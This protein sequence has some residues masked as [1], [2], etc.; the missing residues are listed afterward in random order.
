MVTRE[1]NS[2]EAVFTRALEPIE[3]IDQMER[4]RKQKELKIL[5]NGP[6]KLAQAL[7]ITKD[8]NGVLLNSKSLFIETGIHLSKCKIVGVPRIGVDYAKEHADWPLRFYIK[9]NLFISKK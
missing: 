1:E 4:L 7:H 3:G 9:N 5:A 8:L 2:P 6:G